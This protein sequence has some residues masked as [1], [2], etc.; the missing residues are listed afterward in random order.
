MGAVR[1]S[2]SALAQTAYALSYSKLWLPGMPKIGLK[3]VPLSMIGKMG[4]YHIDI[5]GPVAAR[6]IR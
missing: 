3:L 6:S 4:L 5:T 1:L 2:D